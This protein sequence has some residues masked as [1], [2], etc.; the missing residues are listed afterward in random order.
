MH[1]PFD[2][3]SIPFW[4]IDGNRR[5]R[6]IKLALRPLYFSPDGTP[7]PWFFHPNALD[8]LCDSDFEEIFA[9]ARI[10]FSFNHFTSFFARVTQIDADCAFLARTLLELRPDGQVNL[11]K[12][13]DASLRFFAFLR[14]V[15]EF[16]DLD[17]RLNRLMRFAIRKTLDE[18]RASEI[19]DVYTAISLIARDLDVDTEAPPVSISMGDMSFVSDMIV[20]I[21]PMALPWFYSPDGHNWFTELADTVKGTFAVREIADVVK[22]RATASK[23]A[24]TRDFVDFLTFVGGLLGRRV[25]LAIRGPFPIALVRLCRGGREQEPDLPGERQQGRR[26]PPADHVFSVDQAPMQVPSRGPSFRPEDAVVARGAGQA[27][28]K[29]PAPRDGRRF[30]REAT[31]ERRQQEKALSH[32][33]ATTSA[34]VPPPVASAFDPVPVVASAPLMTPP[35]LPTVQRK[36]VTPLTITFRT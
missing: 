29:R 6:N 19:W 9:L 34:P 8:S 23:T 5:W 18:L 22:R 24:T 21:G 28:G 17:D 3:Q 12:L 31:S 4:H 30:F 1:I 27:P 13:R 20:L 26:W 25:E 7:L 36:A 15:G 11:A 2:K 16:R 33:V 35:V 14:R 32:L 10:P